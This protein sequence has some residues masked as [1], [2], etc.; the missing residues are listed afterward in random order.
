MPQ[1]SNTPLDKGVEKQLLAN[2]ETVLGRLSKEDMNTFLFSF[3][4]KT[5][6]LM[7]AK[8]LAVAILLKEG[9]TKTEISRSLKV[10][11]AT[12]SKME[13]FLESRGSGYQLAINKLGEEKTVKEF[14]K[15][16]IQLAKYSIRAAGG[17]VKSDIL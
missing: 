12:I 10:T 1:V 4:S 3:L 17:Y 11:I 13:L 5:E 15:F 2:L 7:L 8:R 16:L 6:R 9:L 14:K